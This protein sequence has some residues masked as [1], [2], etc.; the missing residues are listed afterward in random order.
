[1]SRTYQV[2]LSFAGEQR[3]YVEEV[4]RHLRAHS[5][6]VF[7]D[8]F[9][10]VGLWGKDLA[11]YFHSMYFSQAEY[12]VLFISKEYVNKSWPRHEK[13]A[14]LSRMI[15]EQREYVIPVRFDDTPCDGLPETI[16]YMDAAK[17]HPAVIASLI[18]RKLGVPA[19]SGKASDIPS[20]RL[21]A[22]TGVA[23]IDY[24]SYNG[25]FAIGSGEWHFETK[26]G[27]CGAEKVYLY[28][29]PPSINGVAL[30]HKSVRSIA[31]VENAR[32]LDFTSRYRKVPLGRVAVLR[33]TNGF[34]AAVRI[35]GINTDADLGSSAPSLGLFESIL[36]L[37]FG[38]RVDGSDSFAGGEWASSARPWS[39]HYL[40]GRA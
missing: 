24:K 3:P 22:P 7:Y 38:I 34:Y 23:A 30:C 28:N 21:S 13:R 6:R 15:N 29:D 14:A 27:E 8:G 31:G 1:M 39:M 17:H 35:A 9:E 32:S 25:R 12:A 36:V 18:A 2:A 37:E 33:N 26:W 11:E 40:P 16:G 4:A 5:I 19:F 20:P 10:Q